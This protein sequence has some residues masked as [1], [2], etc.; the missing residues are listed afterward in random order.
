VGVEHYEGQLHSILE[1]WR[2]LER[3][4]LGTCDTFVQNRLAEFERELPGIASGELSSASIGQY[5]ERLIR[6]LYAG[7]VAFSLPLAKQTIRAFRSDIAAPGRVPIGF[8][9]ILR[10]G[11]SINLFG[12]PKNLDAILRE[13]IDDQDEGTIWNAAELLFGV[14]T[15][16][17]LASQDW[18]NADHF[19]DMATRGLQLE[20]SGD[21]ADAIRAVRQAEFS[22]LNALTKRFRIGTLGPV[23][24]ADGLSRVRRIYRD[25]RAL[26]DS[27][28]EHHGDGPPPGRHPSSYYRALSERAA[29]ALFTAAALGRNVRAA[30]AAEK[31]RKRTSGVNYDAGFELDVAQEIQLEAEAA[32]EAAEADLLKCSELW[33]LIG[34]STPDS[35]ELHQLQEHSALNTMAACVLRRILIPRGDP[36]TAFP[37]SLMQKVEQEALAEWAGTAGKRSPLLA[38]ELWTFLYLRGHLEA[39]EMLKEIREQRHQWSLSLDAALFEAIQ[40]LRFDAS[41]TNRR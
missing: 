32:L 16:V 9:L 33:I 35:R 37:D 2:R 7:S 20:I 24:N 11:E 12:S 36:F 3:V 22:Y 23:R 39:R 19:A 6:N 4:M 18:S 21:D 25:A 26:L 17:A 27:C 5:I 38:A 30:S 15:C 41:F 31:A 1:D 34:S 8:H 28:V 13:L 14:A 40:D 29:L 10:S